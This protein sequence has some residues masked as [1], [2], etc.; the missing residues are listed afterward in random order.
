M[1][2]ASIAATQTACTNNV[3]QAEAG[4]QPE[5]ALVA[6]ATAETQPEA[7][8][9][10][11]NSLGNFSGL[12]GNWTVD[13]KTAGMKMDISFTQEGGYKQVMDSKEPIVNEGTWEVVDD[14]HIKI[15]TPN[16]KGQ[17]WL[18]TDLTESSVNVC[19]NPE[20]AKPLT[21]PL[22]RVK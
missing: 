14:K 15:V 22:Q 16:S 21:L 13:A 3:K 5:T 18:I 1:A 12:V 10:P 19:W 17:T 20:S 11:E 9:T 6:Q 4:A 2:I 8:A 7:T